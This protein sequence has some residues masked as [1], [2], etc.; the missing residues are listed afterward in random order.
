M[1]SKPKNDITNQT[2]ENVADV[3]NTSI[4]PFGMKDKLGYM[5]GDFGNDFFFI[6]VSSF[7]M[8]Y[9]TNVL[10]ISAAMVGT[11]FLVSRILDAFTDIGMGRIVDTSKPNKH[12]RYRVWIRRMRVPVVLAGVLLFLPFAADFNEAGK[13]VFIYCTYILWGSICYTAINIP[14]G[15][16]AG[17]ITADPVQRAE[18]STFRSIGAALAGLIVGAVAPLVIYVNG[19]LSGQRF[20]LLACVFA[21]CAFTC[22]S[23]CYSW[24]LER[25]TVEEKKKEKISAGK[26]VKELFSN[27]ALLSI[28][29]A[30]IVLLI[31][32]LLSQSMNVY[33]YNDYFKNPGA[34]AVASMLSTA[35][36]LVLAPFAKTIIQKWG[37]KEACSAALIFASAMYFLI[38][39]MHV[40]N[41]W[42]FCALIFFGNLG[43]GLFNLMIWAFITDVIDYQ[44]VI[45][46][47]RDDGTVYGIYSFSRKLG[48]ALAGGLGGYVLAAIG[49]VTG[50]GA[51][52]QTTSVVN[53][54]YAV[55]TLAPAAGYLV[56]GLI[57]LFWYPLSKKKIAENQRL[58]GLDTTEK[59]A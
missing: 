36:T 13:I 11:L 30:A 47:S 38:Y 15:S 35:V 56:I 29:V 12:G 10:G 4:R 7:L 32:M 26:F 44:E 25:V 27:Q 37:K 16:M 28:I 40:T 53:S 3:V 59:D 20:F 50:T 57:I 14:Y 34:M 18:L 48:Q 23:F 58:L 41:P 43:S 33:L 45:S 49:Y 6:L 2:T 19:N 24:C 9:Y 17:A 39:F 52:Q 31:A 5:F 55:A 42:I 8:I 22:Y 46:G 54:I 51:V 1:T 21:L